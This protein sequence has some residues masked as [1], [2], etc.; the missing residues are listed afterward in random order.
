M[1]LPPFTIVAHEQGTRA[2]HLWRRDGIGA[3]DAATIM[4]ESPF[5]NSNELLREKRGAVLST[6]PNAAMARGMA[7]EPEARRHYNAHTG[8]EMVPVCLQST[9]YTWLR[10][11]LDGLA[12][13]HDAVVEIKCGKT[14]YRTTLQTNSVPDYYY[15]QL[16][17]ILAVTGLESIDFWCYWP[18]STPLL[19]AVPRDPPY[20]ELLLEREWVFWQQ[21]KENPTA[22][23]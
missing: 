16:Q 12:V 4:G 22:S 7:L 5:K 18:G 10:A 21:L 9:Q 6:S 13:D 3:S 8:R 19:L 15:G 11:S 17:H 1:S 23:K 2:W 20:I 14:A